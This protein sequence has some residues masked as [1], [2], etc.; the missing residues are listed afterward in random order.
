MKE[1]T[2][3][4]RAYGIWYAILSAATFGLIPLFSIPVLEKGMT[5][6]GVLFYRFVFACVM[7]LVL[8]FFNRKELR[9]TLREAGC[10]ALFGLLYD[11]SAVC[12]YYGYQYMSSGS[13]TTLLFMY[14]VWTAVIMAVFFHE[15]PNVK[16]YLAILL[17]IIGVYFLSGDQ[18]MDEGTSW[19][20]VG[21]VLMSGVSYAAYMVLVDRMQIRSMGS[22]K[23]TFYVFVFAT[24]IMT[25]FMLASG[26]GIERI[27]D[28]MSWINLILLAAIPTVLSN[29]VLIMAISRI[30]STLSAI[31]GAFEPAV[32]VGVG[33]A[34]LGE[35]F[36]LH[37][38]IGI[39]LIVGAVI[40]L[41]LKK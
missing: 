10:L 18:K 2:S 25:I 29:V 34:I 15:R 26:K 36:T 19:L 22:L 17:A 12:L 32:A 7:M 14:P 35:P 9:I 27:P 4:S 16:T 41:V 23:L 40:L 28:T 30:G 8:L 6:Y 3:S 37:S 33:V 5:T 13:A 1:I 24:I 31:L 11:I 20:V 39:L 21:I 38:A